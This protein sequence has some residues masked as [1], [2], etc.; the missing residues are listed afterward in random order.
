MSAATRPD[1]KALTIDQLRRKRARGEPLSITETAR[2]LGMSHQRVYT[3]EK[4]A[5]AKLRAYMLRKLEG[6]A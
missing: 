6:A 3:A 2:L 5:L 1:R 4:R